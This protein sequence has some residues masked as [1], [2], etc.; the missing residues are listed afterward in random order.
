MIDRDRLIGKIIDPEEN[1]QQWAAHVITGVLGPKMVH[2]EQ[3]SIYSNGG[4]V[5]TVKDLCRLASNTQLEKIAKKLG[6]K[7]D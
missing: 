5:M 3:E 4:G 6:V 1:D 7:I 2:A